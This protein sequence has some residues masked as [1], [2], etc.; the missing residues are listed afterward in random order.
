MNGHQLSVTIIIVVAMIVS[1]VW[2]WINVKYG[3][4]FVH[5]NI[6]Q[7]SE[8]TKRIIESEKDGGSS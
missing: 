8:S 7:D 1:V 3:S 4:G 6:Q 2:H 5:S